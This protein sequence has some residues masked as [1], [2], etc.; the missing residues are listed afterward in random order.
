MHGS[1]LR[2]AAVFKGNGRE[3]S[4][5]QF[6][7][8][9]LFERLSHMLKIIDLVTVLKAILTSIRCKFFFLFIGEP[10]K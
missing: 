10:T 6:P 1:N 5:A 2:T 4:R 7:L 8:P 3:F 9:L